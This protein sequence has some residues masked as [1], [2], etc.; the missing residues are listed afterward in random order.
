MSDTRYRSDEVFKKT[1]EEIRE[2]VYALD[3]A[4]ASKALTSVTQ[5]QI[6]SVKE[7]KISLQ[8]VL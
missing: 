4:V 7:A 3:Y 5:D 2:I 8:G 6:D 1:I